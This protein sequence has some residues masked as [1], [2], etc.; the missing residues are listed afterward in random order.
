MTGLQ[1]AR[2]RDALVFW[3][4]ANPLTRP[5][6]GFAPWWVILETTGRRSGKVRRTPLAAGPIDGDTAWLIAVHGD[7]SSFARNLAVNPNVR[8]KHRGR[9]RTGTATLL[10]LDDAIVRRFNA[11]ARSATLRGVGIDPR[12]VRVELRG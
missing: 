1:R 2:R 4:L 6:A 7:H 10:P 9:W 5:L 3:K 11:Y 12:L 8:L